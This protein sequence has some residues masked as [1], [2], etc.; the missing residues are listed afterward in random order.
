MTGSGTS[1]R[2]G[3]SLTGPAAFGGPP[4][5]GVLRRQP[6]DFR[7]VERPGQDPVGEG[8]H[9]W[10]WV[11]KRGQNTDWVAR[12]LAERLGCRLR[13]IG[14]AGL[15][16]RHAVTGQWFSAPWP[17]ARALPEADSLAGEGFAVIDRRRHTRKLKHGALA[18][19]RF[20]LWVREVDGDRQRAEAVL[21]SVS[22]RGVPNYFGPQRFGRGGANLARARA[23]FAGDWHPRRS[24][25]GI[26]L[27]AARSWLF[28]RVLAERVA[29]DCWDRPLE[30]EAFVL[31]GSGSF[32]L[33]E[34]GDPA[35]AE[36]LDRFDIHPSGPL[37]G[38][39]ELPSRGECR[40]LERAVAEAEAEIARGLEAAGMDQERRALRL[41]P[42]ELEWGWAEDDLW[43][44]FDLPAGC[45]ATAVLA[46]LVE[47]RG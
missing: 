16:D 18:G 40:D 13:D 19:N 23:M 29:R 42:G 45:F 41:R 26:H 36:R 10:L 34:A 5:S 6:E 27:S 39:G 8:E 7:V 4:L 14:Y 3:G 15:K 31:D 2:A 35:I 22:R 44:A 11:E 47:E 1:D 28:N 21:D 30:G 38:R 20:R 9:L 33:P 46:E 25:R 32:F 12:R 17:I 37:W 24:Q 43:L